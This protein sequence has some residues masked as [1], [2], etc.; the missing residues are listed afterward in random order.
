MHRLINRVCEYQ[1]SPHD[2]GEFR[3]SSGADGITDSDPVAAAP[4][5]QCDTSLLSAA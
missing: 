3:H 1:S 4:R 2:A 5:H